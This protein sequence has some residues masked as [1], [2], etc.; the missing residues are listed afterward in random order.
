M[1]Q[2]VEGVL[3]FTSMGACS[4]IQGNLGCGEQSK[5]LRMGVIAFTISL[6][7]AVVMLK[8]GAAPGYRVALFLPFLAAANGVWQGLYR[9]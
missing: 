5:R 7:I 9:T 4:I 6:V 1:W 3:R 8:L 2:G